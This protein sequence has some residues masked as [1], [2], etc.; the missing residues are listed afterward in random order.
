[1]KK[2]FSL[3]EVLITLTILGVIIAV[4]IP[5]V[6]LV[7]DQKQFQTGLKKALSALN[8]AIALNSALDNITPGETENLYEY[9]MKRMNVAKT[10]SDRRKIYLV[11][12]DMK[13][14]VFY[15]TDGIRYEFR[16]GEN[17]NKSY[18]LDIDNVFACEKSQIGEKE[19][20]CEGCGSY[21]LTDNPSGTKEPPCVILVD[22]NGDKKPNPKNATCHDEE[23]AKIN[24]YKITEPNGSRIMD[25]Y[26]VLITERGAIPYGDLAQRAT[27]EGNKN[28]K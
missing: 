10:V 19:Y 7:T 14:A 4:T 27:Y 15:T 13:N 16:T 24:G 25:L 22:V 18:K 21:G 20:G 3:A 1:M 11:N 9:L 12:D 28:K 6:T 5:S 17:E 26:A 8:N 2:G 23:C